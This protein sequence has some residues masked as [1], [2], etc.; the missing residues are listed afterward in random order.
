[1][2]TSGSS[3]VPAAPKSGTAAPAT[4]LIAI[5][6][7]AVSPIAGLS[8]TGPVG[9]TAN[10]PAAPTVASVHAFAGAAFSALASQA[11]NL[12]SANLALLGVGSV[13]GV[14]QTSG[15]T[16]SVQ[17]VQLALPTPGNSPVPI[18]LVS[19]VTPA[20]V[21]PP[22][23]DGDGGA[24][25]AVA[26]RDAAAAA[27]TVADAPRVGTEVVRTPATVV[28]GRD[29]AAANGRGER[30]RKPVAAPAKALAAMAAPGLADTAG[31]GVGGAGPAAS[32]MDTGIAELDSRAT[33]NGRWLL[34]AALAGAVALYVR[35]R[36]M[37]AR[38]RH[39]R[40]PKLQ[41]ASRVRRPLSRPRVA[42]EMAH[43]VHGGRS[44]CGSD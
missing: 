40:L 14:Q 35:K 10:E 15:S 39:A 28:A 3:G 23:V 37:A 13:G 11:E 42:R 9:S 20:L 16:A 36:R 43:R 27:A 26:G 4:T 17:V 5:N 34:L 12:V 8:P 24:G 2:S 32:G 7:P 18:R 31:T 19:L 41:T 30:A 25:K 38:G 21:E 29:T 33:A 22:R 6:V 44:V 1:M